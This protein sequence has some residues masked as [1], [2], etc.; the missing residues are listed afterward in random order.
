MSMKTVA[1]NRALPAVILFLL[2]SVVCLFALLVLA[3]IERPV[4]SSGSA[5]GALP[6]E[7]AGRAQYQWKMVTTWP[8]NFPGLG[9]TPRIFAEWVEAMSEG[10]LRIR[11]YGA[12]ELVPA[13]QVFEAVSQGTAQMGHSS[14]YYWGGKL[15]ASPFFTTVPFGLTAQEMNAWLYHGGGMALWRKAYA[16][17]NLVPLAGGNTGVQMAGWFNREIRSID[18]LKGLKMRLPGIAG[19]VL[20]RAG[21]TA[22][23]LPGGEIYTAMQTGVID[24]TDWVGPY[25]DQAFNLHK[26]ARYYYYPGW[27]E[28]GPSLE[29]LVNQQA[30][31]SL[32]PDLQQIVTVAARAANQDMLDQYTALNNAAL[33]TLVDEHDVQ[34][35]QLPDDVLRQLRVLSDEV[36][37]EWVAA[38]PLVAEIYDSWSSFRDNVSEYH[39]ISEQAFL[40]AR[41]LPGSDLVE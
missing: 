17:F 18:D 14:A 40:R 28:P 26:V 22:V 32:P 15:P 25:N 41:A 35:R 2:A 24:A 29:F 6:A 27:H 19:Q 10:R 4:A 9:T 23:T 31:E 3:S 8:V 38:D 1:I 36:I 5:T 13:L 12:G 30:W 16:P 39:H 21:G 11:V 33:H 34:L 20:E 37:A 7:A